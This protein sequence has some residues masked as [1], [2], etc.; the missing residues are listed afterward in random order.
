MNAGQLNR[1]LQFQEAQQ[2]KDETGELVNTWLPV[3]KVWASMV[4]M[5][6]TVLFRAQQFEAK[7]TRAF[8]IRWR[9]WVT[10]RESLRF[11]FEGQPFFMLDVT[12]IGRREGLS[13]IAWQRA[14]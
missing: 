1:R 10:P 9:K 8:E 12:E 2:V 5:T 6:G 13:I 4:P 11:L 7:S 14:E 3:A